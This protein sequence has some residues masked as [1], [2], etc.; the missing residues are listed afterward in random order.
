MPQSEEEIR[1]AVWEKN[2]QMIDA[3]NQEAA[4]GMHWY[5]L[6]MNQLGDMVSLKAGGGV[7]SW[8]GGVARAGCERG[9][10]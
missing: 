3:H 2:L 8:C 9:R 7:A 10:D 4:L 6:G 5:E 1:R